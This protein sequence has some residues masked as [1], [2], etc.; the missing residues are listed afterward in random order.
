[1]NIT[2]GYTD[3]ADG[4]LYYES[5]GSGDPLILL[6]GFAVDRRMWDGQF[7]ALAGRFR[8]VRYD[9]RGFGKSSLPASPY[10]HTDDLK[11]LLDDLGI[12]QADLLGLSLGGGVA[13]DFALRHS[14]MVRKLA[15]SGSVISGLRWSEQGHLLDKAVW[16][17]ARA[18]GME[19]GKQAWLAHPLFAPLIEHP[20]AYARLRQMIADYSGWHFVNRNPLTPDPMP[21]LDRLGEI[22][23][24]TLVMIG[25]RDM[26]DF[27]HAAEAL[28]GGIP[29][30]RKVTLAGMGHMAPMENPEAFNRAV[31]EYLAE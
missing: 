21:A 31:I 29:G 14:Q 5:A 26:P 7:E 11:S 24:P 25:E 12:A 13:V 9:L 17:T 20:E 18:E 28:A 30:A 10:S 4:R 2:T 16:D 22:A 19:A 3:L 6:H 15:V 8:V 23:A 1:M 27:Q